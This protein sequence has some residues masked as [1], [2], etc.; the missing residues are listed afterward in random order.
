MH[1]ASL[2]EVVWGKKWN[3]TKEPGRF[4][5]NDRLQKMPWSRKCEVKFSLVPKSQPG[6]NK[7]I[8]SQIKCYVV[9]T[10]LWKVLLVKDNNSL[11]ILVS[12]Q[13][14]FQQ[15]S[16]NRRRAN[17]QEYPGFN[18]GLEKSYPRQSCKLNEH[19]WRGYLEADTLVLWSSSRTRDRY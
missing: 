7:S 3:A 10:E 19:L 12:E 16:L 13:S 6:L 1:L 18:A 9:W 14:L 17:R 15:F 5:F 2:Y 11:V 8:S 4:W